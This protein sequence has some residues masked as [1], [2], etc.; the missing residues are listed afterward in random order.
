MYEKLHQTIKFIL[1][2]TKFHVV[3]DLLTRLD[4][5]LDVLVGNCLVF[6]GVRPT[7]EPLDAACKP[8]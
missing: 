7:N 3:N 5:T 1:D 4:T 6:K 2:Q 8:A